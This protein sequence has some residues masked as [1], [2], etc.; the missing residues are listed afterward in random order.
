MFVLGFMGSGN[1]VMRNWIALASLV[2][3]VALLVGCGSSKY[4]PVSG[5]LVFPDGTPVTGLEGGTVVF[6]TTSPDGQLVSASGPIDAQGKFTLGTEAVSDGALP[7][8]HRVLITPP[9]VSGDVPPPPVIDPKY[10]AFETSGLEVEVT[11]GKNESVKLTVE[12]PKK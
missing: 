11:A 12:P 5:Q 2:V 7:G 10:G 8:K 1:S 6:E 9:A 3:G 4:S